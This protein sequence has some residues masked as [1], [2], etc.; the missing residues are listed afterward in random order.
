MHALATSMAVQVMLDTKACSSASSD[1]HGG[2]ASL[3]EAMSLAETLGSV[4]HETERLKAAE[5]AAQKL[6]SDLQV[7]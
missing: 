3:A 7:S 1:V 2:S 6:A 4:Q 5:T